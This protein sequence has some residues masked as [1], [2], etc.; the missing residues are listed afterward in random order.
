MSELVFYTLD[1]QGQIMK[2]IVDTDSE[3]ITSELFDPE[4]LNDTEFAGVAF[5]QFYVESGQLIGVIYEAGPENTI[6]NLDGVNI[7]EIAQSEVNYEDGIPIMEPIVDYQYN[8]SVA[9]SVENG[10]LPVDLEDDKNSDGTFTMNDV[11]EQINDA[12]LDGDFDS[13]ST[14]FLV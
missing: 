6:V 14:D 7:N 13:S 12:K 9:D 1:D 4:V 8:I 2:N 3:S 10:F 5:D 11:N